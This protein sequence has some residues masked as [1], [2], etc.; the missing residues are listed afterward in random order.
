MVWKPLVTA[1]PNLKSG[2]SRITVSFLRHQ[3]RRK[4]R[5]NNERVRLLSPTKRQAA[6]SRV[7]GH[8][9]SVLRGAPS[10]AGLVPAG[11]CVPWRGQRLSTKAVERT[12]H[13]RPTGV[14]QGDQRSR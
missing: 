2:R 8:L 9:Q 10:R 14:L 1:S 6:L 12:V 5:Q 4:E 7:R 3:S 13:A 11:L